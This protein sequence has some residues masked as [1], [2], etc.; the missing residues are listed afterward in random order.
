MASTNS[1]ILGSF[2]DLR[3]RPAWLAILP[4]QQ[5]VLVAE[6]LACIFLQRLVVPGTS[7]RT[8]PMLLLVQFAAVGLLALLNY[9]MIDLNR[10]LLLLAGLGGLTFSFLMTSSEPDVKLMAFLFVVVNYA[11]IFWC[12]VPSSVILAVRSAF[13][14]GMTVC[15]GLGLLQV[16]GQLA[17]VPKV[18][19]LAFLPSSLLSTYFHN[20]IPVEYG[21]EIFK[22]DGMFLLEPSVFCQWLAVAL[23]FELSGR[24]QWWRCILFFAGM[25]ASFSGTGFMALAAGLPFQFLRGRLTHAVAIAGLLVLG[26]AVLFVTPMGDVF[27]NR[28]TEESTNE[29]SSAQVRFVKPYARY[30]ASLDAKGLLFGH[31]PGSADV[32]L[33]QHTETPDDD[34]GS[35]SVVVEED[36]MA[37]YLTGTAK[38]QEGMAS[39]IIKVAYEYGLLG[40]PF[41]AGIIYLFVVAECPLPA[42]VSLLVTYTVLGGWLVSPNVT[43]LCYLLLFLKPSD[44][45][46][47]GGIPASS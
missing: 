43:L 14:G 46:R 25:L 15:A 45:P 36:P 37:K 12:V 5:T 35:F 40:L 34:H 21:S 4:S 22:A 24:R 10:L 17:G 41:A 16:V 18:D 13:V 27:I 33:D 8:I 39:T 11:T 47:V 2:A 30:F 28:L 32:Q 23:L 7:T 3:A 26:A 20:H 9:K 1:L 38:E 6:V 31:G 29:D 19:V 44:A 42:K